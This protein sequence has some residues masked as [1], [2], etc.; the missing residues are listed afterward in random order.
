MPDVDIVPAPEEAPSSPQATTESKDK[1]SPTK[2]ETES[3]NP[4]GPKDS[5]Q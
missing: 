5:E 2:G 1:P 3:V 4:T